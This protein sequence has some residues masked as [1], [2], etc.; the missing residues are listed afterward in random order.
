MLTHPP[1]LSLV[2]ATA[3]IFTIKT[4]LSGYYVYMYKDPRTDLPF[5][6]G[7][8]TKGRYLH[9][10]NE[11]KDNTENIKKYAYIQGLRN[12]G[13]TPKIV[14]IQ[15]D[16]LES[17]AYDLERDLIKYWGRKNID[18]NGILTNICEDNRPP[19]HDWSEERR[20]QQSQLMN[21]I[22]NERRPGGIYEDGYN[23]IQEAQIA[24]IKNGEHNFQGERNP[25]HKR[26][27][28]G[29]H[30]WQGSTSNFKRLSEGTHPSQIKL[31]CPHCGLLGSKGNMIRWHFD[32]C[33]FR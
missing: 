32:N 17:E 22:V 30:Q 24:R 27:A 3:M 29:T 23:R 21:W 31:T 28:E 10:L 19:R 11:T 8:G 26:L 5:Y 16:M 15:Q 18:E 13:L 1:T 33:K 14:I 2:G 20:E 4:I 12:K 6:I 9:H 25:N 7:K